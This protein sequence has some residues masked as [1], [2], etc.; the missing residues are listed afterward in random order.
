MLE[1]GNK[2]SLNYVDKKGT[3][4]L[5]ASEVKRSQLQHK[6]CKTSAGR[7]FESVKSGPDGNQYGSISQT[8]GLIY[9]TKFT[10][11]VITRALM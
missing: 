5:T 10:N 3:K 11:T 4:K 9:F 6:K 1:G 8:S 2:A 7:G